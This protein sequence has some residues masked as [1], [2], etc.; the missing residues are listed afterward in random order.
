[1]RETGFIQKLD[2]GEGHIRIDV[3]TYE[4]LVGTWGFSFG[5]YIYYSAL[6]NSSA[7]LN[8]KIR[9][10]VYLSAGTYKLYVVYSKNAAYGICNFIVDGNSVGTIDMYN[11]SSLTNQISSITF[12]IT[13]TGLVNFDVL[14][15]SKNA[16]SGGYY[17][18]LQSFCFVRVV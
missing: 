1:M 13:K 16:S 12:T 11:S 18:I 5:T 7:A 6:Y 3:A 2:P 10:R 8:D 17:A 15:S 4:A 14:V 9:Y